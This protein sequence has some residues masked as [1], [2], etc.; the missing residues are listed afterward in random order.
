MPA[1]DV[2]H[3]K[4]ASTRRGASA[5]AVA[6]RIGQMRARYWG[7]LEYLVQQFTALE[8]KLMAE[9]AQVRRCCNQRCGV[10]AVLS[11]LCYSS[12]AIRAVLC[13]LSV[14][15]RQHFSAAALEGGWTRVPSSRWRRR[16]V[17]TTA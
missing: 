12:C 6:Q 11:M 16:A 9:E 3:D 14:C 1:L 4:Q 10:G 7:E 2:I 17:S 8:A 5:L 15:G 13:V